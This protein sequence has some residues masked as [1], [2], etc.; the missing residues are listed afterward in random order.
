MAETQKFDVPEDRIR[1]GVIANL[2]RIYIEM[3]IDDKRKKLLDGLNGEEIVLEFPSLGGSVLFK[4]YD[5]RIIESVG[6][7]EDAAATLVLKSTGEDVTEDM[8][9]ILGNTNSIF[10]ILKLLPMMVKKNVNF[11]GSAFKALRFLRVIMMGNSKEFKKQKKRWKLMQE[12][13]L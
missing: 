1:L 5:R 3:Y 2:L 7:S 11:K 9:P 10:G 6:D 4:I 12:G 8:S 13:K